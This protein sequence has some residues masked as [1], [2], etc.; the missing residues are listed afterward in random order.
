MDFRESLTLAMLQS[1]LNTMYRGMK[2]EPSQLCC[3][4]A[5][6]PQYQLYESTGQF[7]GCIRGIC[8]SQFRMLTGEHL[9][10]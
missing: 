3:I 5:N 8:S 6:N 4:A 10:E 7:F 9:A 2:T 1:G